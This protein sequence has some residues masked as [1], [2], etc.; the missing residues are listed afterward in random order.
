MPKLSLGIIETIGLAAAVVAADTCVKS[1]NVNL[2]GY[3]L[4]K[5]G[6]MAVVKIEGNVG[7]VNSAIQAVKAILKKDQ[8]WSTKVIARPSEYIEDMTRNQETVGY[9]SHK[10]ST[11]ENA[12]PVEDKDTKL[13][14]EEI[15]KERNKAE[16][17]SIQIEI[18]KKDEN[19]KEELESDEN[20]EI[21]EEFEESEDNH[22]E[23]EESVKEELESEED[24][25]IKDNPEESE[26]NQEH[27]DEEL[28]ITCNL[29]GDPKCSRKKGDLRKTCIHYDE[30]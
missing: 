8:I 30:L 21:Q 13:N 26:D 27:L 11:K 20:E 15:S 29:C 23:Y 7:A 2:I 3:E 5:G 24:E 22:T 4:S 28:E 9:D 19:L 25:D 18:D 1:A 14:K 17:K 16:E 10:E 6:G 12:D